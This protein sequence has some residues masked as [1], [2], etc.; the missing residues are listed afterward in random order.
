MQVDIDPNGVM[1]LMMGAVYKSV[2]KWC[3]TLGL[4]ETDIKVSFC[5]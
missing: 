3:I 2:H 1:R 5:I 4:R